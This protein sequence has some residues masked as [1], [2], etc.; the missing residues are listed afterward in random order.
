MALHDILEKIKSDGAAELKAINDA[1][2][3][4]LMKIEE[5]NQRAIKERRQLAVSDAERRASKV[6]GRIVSKARHQAQFITGHLEQ[7]KLEAV[8][9][10]I[11]S[12]LKELSEASYT[13][14]VNKQ[15]STLP[16][17]QTGVFTI[18]EKTSD[19]TKKILLQHGVVENKIQIEEKDTLWGGFV[20]STAITEYDCSFRGLVETIKTQH[21]VEI[22]KQITK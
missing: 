17:L 19:I 8:F 22:A 10:A 2:S 4:E 5:A 9:G 15:L 11:K 18:A 12:E 3:A 21:S 6:A 16:N 7:V 13:E 1:A 14:F 20:Y